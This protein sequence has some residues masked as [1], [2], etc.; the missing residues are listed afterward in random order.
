MS[1]FIDVLPTTDNP[2]DPAEL[3]LFDSIVA[4]K[5][6]LFFILQDLRFTIIASLIFFVL[7]MEF[8]D[9]VVRSTVSYAKSSRYALSIVKTVMFFLC[10]FIVHHGWKL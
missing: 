3:Q 2:A 7:S 4:P 8:T 6:S 10:L 9:S 1:D 5:G